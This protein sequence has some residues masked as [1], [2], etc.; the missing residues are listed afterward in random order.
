MEV[1][2]GNQELAYANI[3]FSR[4][5]RNIIIERQIE[6]KKREVQVNCVIGNRSRI[7]KDL[8][9]PDKAATYKLP[10]IVV[11]RTGYQINNSRLASLHNEVLHAPSTASRLY[12]I[13]TPVPVDVSYTVTVISKYPGDND[14]ICSNFIPFF[15]SDLFVTT[16]HPKFT[17]VKI[18][19]Q[20][21]MGSSISEQLPEELT[22]STDNFTTT[23]F[24]FTFKTWLYAGM[25][26]VPA[27]EHYVKYRT[28]TFT[29]TSISTWIDEEG[30][31]Q[32]AEISTEVSTTLSTEYAG[33]VPIIRKIW[34]EMHAVPY[35]DPL[36]K[37]PY[38]RDIQ[39]LSDFIVNNKVKLTGIIGSLSG[40]DL[41]TQISALIEPS[42][43]RTIYDGLSARADLYS[44]EHY[45]EDLQNGLIH[46]PQYDELHWIIDDESGNLIVDNEAWGRL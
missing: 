43:L 3:L 33:F 4:I 28:S 36:K 9:N 5:F 31:E 12:D 30:H 26:K 27:T 45:F 23:S 13:M 14:L 7:F 1:R 2:S 44:N 32:S 46:N 8:E 41:C 20:I 25:N 29:S 38:F 42:S 11:T 10:L 18:D 21:V 35:F 39:Q 34:L 6:G 15:N 40:E 17:D 16:T 37:S 24:N 19:C 22:S